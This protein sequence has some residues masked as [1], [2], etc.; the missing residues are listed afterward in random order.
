ML[1]LVV[2]TVLSVTLHFHV[3]GRKVSL[4][5]IGQRGWHDGRGRVHFALFQ[6]HSPV[7]LRRMSDFSALH[8]HFHS[9]RPLSYVQG[10]SFKQVTAHYY[11]CPGS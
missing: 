6:N 9:I 5:L 4:F 11:F 2:G 8:V 10:C 1:L 7:P 3:E